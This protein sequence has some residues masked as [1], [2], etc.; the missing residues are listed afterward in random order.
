MDQAKLK[1]YAKVAAGVLV[2]LLVVNTIANRVPAVKAA[3][4]KIN[5]GF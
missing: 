1:S 2:T 4:D 3:R 5:T